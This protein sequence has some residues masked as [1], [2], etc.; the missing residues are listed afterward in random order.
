MAEGLALVDA[1]A[2][3]AKDMLLNLKHSIGHGT[4]Q[5]AT[6]SLYFTDKDMDAFLLNLYHT[7]I[8]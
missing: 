6:R 8:M 1:E 5:P 7:M 2:L 4:L 3:V